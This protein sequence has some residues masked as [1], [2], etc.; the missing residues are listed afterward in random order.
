MVEVSYQ[1]FAADG[2]GLCCIFQPLCKQLGWTGAT[3]F[4]TELLADNSYGTGLGPMWDVSFTCTGSET[5]LMECDTMTSSG[6]GSGSG[7]GTSVCD[8]TKTLAINCGKIK[9]YTFTPD[10]NHCGLAE[11]LHGINSI[12]H[13]MQ[14]LQFQHLNYCM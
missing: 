14:I 13:D 1:D 2:T 9:S 4:T 6:S 12:L 11:L 5:N 3:R 7:S 8:D 10:I